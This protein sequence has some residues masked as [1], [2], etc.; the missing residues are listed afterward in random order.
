MIEIARSKVG[1]LA[2]LRRADVRELP[3]LG[4]FDLVWAVNGVLNYLLTSE[5]LIAVLTAMGRN[6]ARGGVLV[7]D[8]NTPANHRTLFTEEVVVQ[9]WRRRLVWWGLTPPDQL[10]PGSIGEAGSRSM[11]SRVRCICITSG[12]SQKPRCGIRSR[13]WDCAVRRS[14]G[15]TTAPFSHS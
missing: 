9:L 15:S 7:F 8:L 12:T 4:S 2:E 10:R 11:E 5:E 3:V 1:D 13:G 14:A 6:L